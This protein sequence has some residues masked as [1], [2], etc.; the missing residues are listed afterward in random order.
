MQKALDW[1]LEESATESVQ[2]DRA[3]PRPGF[4]EGATM[5]FATV[6]SEPSPSVFVLAARGE[7]VANV[8]R[9][10]GCLL[11]PKVGDKVLWARQGTESFI[12]SVLT[13]GSDAQAVLSVEGDVELRARRG[14]VAVVGER[15]VEVSSGGEVSIN[16]PSVT[17]RSLA[18]KL[19]SASVSV[20]GQALDA[21]LEKVRV[22]AG[23]VDSRLERLSQTL[24]RSYRRVEEVDQ[25]KAGQ[26]V[27][28]AEGNASLHADNTLMTANKLVKLNGEQVHIA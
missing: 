17:V 24:K 14:K 4:Q 10:A 2:A 20:V 28:S 12:L 25:V 23:I 9:A 16:A 1:V 13:R 27:M 15:E 8:R 26:I 22:V 21:N 6:Y 3:M 11:E 19:L 7:V 5:A 18:T